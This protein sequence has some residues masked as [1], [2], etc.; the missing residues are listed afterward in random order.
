[1]IYVCVPSRNDASTV[2]LLLWKTRQV[3]RDFPR[4]YH[5]LVVDDASTDATA[6]VLEPYRRALPMS[7]TR[8]TTALGYAATIE[9]LLRDA[10]GRS[11]H[12][13]RD[14]V[15]LIPA[16][17]TISPDS[18]PA[19]VK[20]LDS[21][22]DLV[23]GEALVGGSSLGLGLVRRTAAWLLR[24]GVSVPGVRD[25]VS[26]FC[27]LRLVTLQHCL[28]ER[29]RALLDTNGWCAN[30]ELIARSAAHARQIAVVPVPRRA[31]PV[32]GEIGPFGLALDL[33]R[34]GRRLHIAAPAAPIERAS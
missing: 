27:A 5:L 14:A 9:A 7:L 30:A 10:L 25:M 11:D 2:G 15:L 33:Y 6:E 17:F 19:L 32:R 26:G 31:D 20:R 21:G 22:A 24:P 4:E 8:H 18:I 34:T 12:P 13:K 23:V 16:D 28:R 3:F 1:M 29:G